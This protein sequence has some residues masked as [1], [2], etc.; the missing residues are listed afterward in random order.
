MPVLWAE[1]T[2]CVA[3]QVTTW[4]AKGQVPGGL[5]SLILLNA[6][7]CQHDVTRALPAGQETAAIALELSHNTFYGLLTAGR[8]LVADEEEGARPR[9]VWQGKVSPVDIERIGTWSHGRWIWL[10][11]LTDTPAVPMV[12]RPQ[13]SAVCYEDQVASCN[14]SWHG[15]Q[16]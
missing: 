2:P 5:M 6:A 16:P 10:Q 13:A 4:L 12:A 14:V 1:C 7:H 11:C 3:K 15:E 9:W 8:L